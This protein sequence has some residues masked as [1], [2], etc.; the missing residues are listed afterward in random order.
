M[1]GLSGIRPL[2]VGLHSIPLEELLRDHSL[3]TGSDRLAAGL[4]HKEAIVK[5]VI[6]RQ[7]KTHSGTVTASLQRGQSTVILKGVPAE[8]CDNCGEYY[9]SEQ[10]TGTVLDRAETAVR[11]GAE[12][13]ILQF[14]A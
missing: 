3:R 1:L 10:V 12:V 7:G 13:E 2:H 8:I 6:C 5:C 14:A 4:S 11:N 9:L